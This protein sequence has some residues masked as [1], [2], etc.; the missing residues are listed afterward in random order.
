MAYLR[1]N[2]AKTNIKIEIAIRTVSDIFKF[3]EITNRDFTH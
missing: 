1:M 3:S 2:T